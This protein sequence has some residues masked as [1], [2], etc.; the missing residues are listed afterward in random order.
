[1]YFNQIHRDLKPSNVF[2]DAN[3]D[4]KVKKY[5]NLNINK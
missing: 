1:M 2:L 4:V 5:E 3:D